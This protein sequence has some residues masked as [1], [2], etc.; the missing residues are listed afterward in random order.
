[1]LNFK[2]LKFTKKYFFIF[3]IVIFLLFLSSITVYALNIWNLGYRIYTQTKEVKVGSSQACHKVTNTSSN[4][5]FIPTRTTTEWNAFANNSPSGVTIGSCCVSYQGNS[6]G[7][8]SCIY[9][10]TYNWRE[11]AVWQAGGHFDT[12]GVAGH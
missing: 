3:G 9:A 11:E 1:M 2:K 7:G 12:G 4:S 6:C 10:G 8:S 5:Y